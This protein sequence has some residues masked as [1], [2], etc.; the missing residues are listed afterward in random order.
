[1]RSAAD[2]P[3]HSPERVAP[4]QHRG[5]WGV[6]PSSA[7]SVLSAGRRGWHVL[8]DRS[9]LHHRELDVSGGFPWVF[10]VDVRWRR[11]AWRNRLLR[12]R[13]RRRGLRGQAGDRR[14]VEA[15][16]APR[17]FRA[18]GVPLVVLPARDPAA[19]WTGWSSPCTDLTRLLGAPPRGEPDHRAGVEPCTRGCPP[20]PRSS[21]TAPTSIT[22][23]WPPWNPDDRERGAG[24]PA[25][26]GVTEP[27]ESWMTCFTLRS[28][29]IKRHCRARRG[30]RCAGTGKTVLACTG[31][32]TWRPAVL[33]L[34]TFRR[35][36]A[37]CPA[38]FRAGARPRRPGG[39]HRAAPSR[40]ASAPGRLAGDRSDRAVSA[41]TV[42]GA[43]RRESPLNPWRRA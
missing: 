20:I 36:L 3:S 12:A 2:R 43:V 37:P 24:R 11:S 16:L 34:V 28:E 10:V 13:V 19:W 31:R 26:V 23:P 32:I 21:G 30:S 7:A 29:S 8:P 5:A 27:V 35:T 6:A 33:V 41:S 15:L 22:S 9:G 25:P 4:A 1:M 14:A 38:L 39:L 17:G 42:P 18:E 40:D